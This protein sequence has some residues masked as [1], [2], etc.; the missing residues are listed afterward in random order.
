MFDGI[1]NID[2]EPAMAN[3]L[4]VSS[5]SAGDSI[6]DT[7]ID[8]SGPLARA[9]KRAQPFKHGKYTGLVIF[10]EVHI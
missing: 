6:G 8:S 7:H 5:D 10:N 9:S 3:V 1:V 4:R 2:T